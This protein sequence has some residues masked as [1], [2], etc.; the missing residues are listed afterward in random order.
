MDGGEGAGG[1]APGPAGAVPAGEGD[2]HRW[3]RHPAQ[4]PDPGGGGGTD[5]PPGAGGPGGPEC[6]H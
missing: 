6:P 5:R 1:P 3:E 2:V 4:P